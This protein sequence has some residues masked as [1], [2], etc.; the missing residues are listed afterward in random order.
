MPVRAGWQ[1]YAKVGVRN[2]MVIAVASACVAIDIDAEQVAVAL[3]SVAPTVVRCALAEEHLARE[4]D[5]SALSASDVALSR[6]GELVSEASTP[7]TDHRSTAEYRRHAVGV[8]A[9]RLAHRGLAGG[10]VGGTAEET[11]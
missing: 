10:L 6:F 9:R 11:S 5:W 8:L 7:I 4:I 3:G 1:G 2:A